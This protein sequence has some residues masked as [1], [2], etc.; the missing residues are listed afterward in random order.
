MKNERLLATTH[1]DGHGMQ[2]SKEVLDQAA[3]QINGPIVPGMGIEHDITIP[4][5]GKFVKAEVRQLPDGEYGVYGEFLLFDPEMTQ[6]IALPDGEAAFVDV[7]ADKRPFADKHEE[8]PEEIVYSFDPTNFES[9][10]E[11]LKFQKELEDD[12]PNL[13]EMLIRKS[14]IPDPEFIVKLSKHAV[15]F[16]IAHQLLKKVGQQLA[17]DTSNDIAKLYATI[18]NAAIK[19]GKYCIPKNRPI[20]Y[21]FV[22]P[23]TPTIEFVIRTANSATVSKAIHNEKISSAIDD[24]NR[25]HEAITAQKIQFILNE[26]EKWT[27]NYMLTSTGS[28]V[29]SED[30][31]ARREKAVQILFRQNQAEPESD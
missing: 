17:S 29:G 21:V 26:D 31:V 11:M 9:Q 18:R 12:G 27:F 1:V 22:I 28:V 24:A 25:L 8:I 2:M 16:L 7:W 23:G 5:I 6:K 19:Y 13:Q 15:E 4:P 14:L 3:A 20:T 30:A 10:A